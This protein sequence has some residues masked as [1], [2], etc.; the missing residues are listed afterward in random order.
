VYCSTTLALAA[1]EY[2]VHVDPDD[3]PDDLVALELA[4]PKG[5]ALQST[6]TTR[7]PATWR[8]TSA[9]VECQQL[10]DAWIASGRALGLLVPSVII[11]V[12]QNLLLDPRHADMARVTV[13]S[14]FPFSFDPRLLYRV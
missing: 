13:Q 8:D 9:P 1:L 14:A 5:A 7:L 4:V 11:P 6:A 3:A 12:E 2:L 10:G